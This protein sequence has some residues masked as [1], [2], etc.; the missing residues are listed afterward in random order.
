MGWLVRY[1]WGQ[2]RGTVSVGSS[3]GL[4]LG[5]RSI[6]ARNRLGLD[7]SDR[8]GDDGLACGLKGVRYGTVDGLR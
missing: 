6:L 4:A 3:Y 7:C 8:L 5:I 1:G 2:G